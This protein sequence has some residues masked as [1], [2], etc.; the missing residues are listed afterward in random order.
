M[1]IHAPRRRAWLA[2]ALGLLVAPG[3]VTSGEPSVDASLETRRDAPRT[4]LDVPPP[5]VWRGDAPRAPPIDGPARDA[6][7]PR[8]CVTFEPGTLASPCRTDGT[9][10]PGL[11]CGIEASVAVS[12][13]DGHISERDLLAGLCTRRCDPRVSR[14]CGSCG[15]CVTSVPV[16]SGRASIL[17]EGGR[18]ICAQPCFSP[19]GAA[20][21]C[22]GGQACD[23]W[24]EACLPSCATDDDCLFTTSPFAAAPFERVADVAPLPI[25]CATLSGECVRDAG[26]GAIG[27]LCTTDFDCELEHTCWV[28]APG[29]PGRCAAFSDCEARGCGRG[30]VCASLDPAVWV[31][32]TP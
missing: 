29:R 22:L 10:E 17:D 3:C 7:D 19:D 30:A 2:L 15:V 26:P 12:E 20:P 24:A 28:S 23:R 13:L 27:D 6:P 21:T 32:G 5:D 14:S 4:F 11:S 9:C 31:C 18:G 1:Q 8:L 25:T 16:G